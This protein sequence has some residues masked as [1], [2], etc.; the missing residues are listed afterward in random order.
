[1]NGTNIISSARLAAMVGLPFPS[2]PKSANTFLNLGYTSQPVFF[3]CND[4][5][6]TPLLLYAADYPYS[7]Y[8]NIS[9]LTG[10]SRSPEQVT[11]LTDNGLPLISQQGFRKNWNECLACG[12]VY[13]SLQRMGHEMPARCKQCMAD[14]CW[15]GTEVDTQPSYLD[16]SLALSPNVSFAQW[17]ATIYN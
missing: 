8:G 10:S 2:V 6:D 9:A 1:M 14:Y 11:M 12:A 15:N 13:R 5:M 7:S 3:G 16:P 4:P 17:N